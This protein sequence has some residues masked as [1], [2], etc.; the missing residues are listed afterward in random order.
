MVVSGF[1]PFLVGRLRAWF[2]PGCWPGATL[3]P[4][5]QGPPEW[6]SPGFLTF[7]PGS[8]GVRA[9]LCGQAHAPSLRGTDAHTAAS[10]RGALGVL[11]DA[12]APQCPFQRPPLPALP[13]C[14]PSS[15]S[16]LRPGLL[17]WPYPPRP[18][19]GHVA[20]SDPP[21]TT[22]LPLSSHASRARS[23]PAPLSLSRQHPGSSPPGLGVSALS[24]PTC[25][26][27]CDVVPHELAAP[28]GRAASE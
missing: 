27:L 18:P 23:L 21:A 26:S 11:S 20:L 28:R 13:R 24:F 5:P 10:T 12:S 14:H 16:R 7:S 8:R 17:Q 4:L 9:A 15:P 6:R 22:P 1:S 2:L 25:L 3:S 19:S